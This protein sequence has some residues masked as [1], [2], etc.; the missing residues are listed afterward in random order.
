MKIVNAKNK[1]VLADKLTVADNFFSRSK[2][3]LGKSALGK[4]EALHI[5]PCNSIHSCFMKFEFDAVFIN[6]KNEVI[7]MIENMPAW[8]FS[9]ICFSANSVIE[10][11]AGT[12]KETETSVG[13][14]LEF[15]E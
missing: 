7:C 2:G 3:L 1:K 14:I 5:I 12:I 13:D 4:G 11:P 6:K 8:R 15:M 10:L 9:E